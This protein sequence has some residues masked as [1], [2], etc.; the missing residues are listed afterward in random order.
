MFI[1][2]F[3]Y[4][5]LAMLMSVFFP[6]KRHKNIHIQLATLEIAFGSRSAASLHAVLIRKYAGRMDFQPRIQHVEWILHVRVREGLCHVDYYESIKG[7]LQSNSRASHRILFSLVA[8]VT[9]DVVTV[10]TLALTFSASLPSF[11]H[12]FCGSHELTVYDKYYDLKEVEIFLL[13]WGDRNHTNVFAIH[14]GDVPKT[15]RYKLPYIE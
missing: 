10:V 7:K 9:A 3:K 1:R 12:R 14:E 2:V 8:C 11:R 4:I 6:S 15:E 5:A 13:D